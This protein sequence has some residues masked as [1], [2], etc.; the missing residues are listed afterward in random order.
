[1]F[2]NR[3]IQ[4]AI[5]FTSSNILLKI[6]TLYKSDGGVQFAGVLCSGHVGPEF[7]V[8]GF[9]NFYFDSANIQKKFVTKKFIFSFF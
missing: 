1:M 2:I 4:K 3:K 7:F 5:E 8:V 6:P 9:H